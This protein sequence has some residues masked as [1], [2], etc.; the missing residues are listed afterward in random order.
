MTV[1]NVIIFDI[2]GTLADCS[3]R[4]PHILDQVPADWDTFDAL[5]SDD[6]PIPGMIR[7]LHIIAINP[8]IKI[9]LLTGRADRNDVQK[10]TRT[11]LKEQGINGARF[12]K[13]LMRGA[14]DRR[15]ATIVKQEQLEHYGY[16]PEQVITIF[17]DDP[18]TVKHLRNLG[19]HVCNVDDRPFIEGEHEGG[20]E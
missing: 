11:W 17:E 4:L 14:G 15:P 20:P 16:T 13:L 12:N 6:A 9:I 2:D 19:Y 7:L 18:A 10:D 5:I 3:H 8:M 1:R